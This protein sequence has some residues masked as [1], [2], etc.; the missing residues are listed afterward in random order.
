MCTAAPPQEQIALI[1]WS[2]LPRIAVR[3]NPHSSAPRAGTASPLRLP[4]RHG[5]RYSPS[6]AARAHA[7]AHC[8]AE[9]WR[10]SIQ[11]RR[12][13]PPC[14]PQFFA[15]LAHPTWCARWMGRSVMPWGT[16][17]RLEEGS[18]H[19]CPLFQVRLDWGEGGG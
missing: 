10:Y 16:D 2:V 6:A 19:S 11:L 1:A 12:I 9:P 15:V 3:L 8:R 4:S 5:R 17:L 18:G 7:D 13:A 14:V